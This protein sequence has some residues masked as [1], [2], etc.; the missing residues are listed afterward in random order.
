MKVL[1]NKLQI[2]NA[3][4]TLIAKGAS[5]LAAPF[6]LVLRRF[7]LS[8]RILLGDFIKSWDVL[9]S[10]EYIENHVQKD[11]PIL[12]IGCHSSEIIVALHKLGYSNLTGAD[13]NPALNEM[14][15][16]NSIRYEITN[17]MKTGFEDASFKAITSISVIEHGFDGHALLKEM[18]R[19]L[20]PGGHFIASFDYW[21][22]KIDTTGVKFYGMDWKIFSKAEVIDLIKLASE[23]GLAQVGE[24]NFDGQDRPIRCGGKKYTF[25]WLVLTK[26]N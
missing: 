10:L 23:Y 2:K 17:F 6:W 25:G 11:E 15:F 26:D 12:D 22:E 4:S 1:L 7:G 8:R 24:M 18:S 5:S 16:Q 3:R 13:L 14:P 19:L 21:P 9:E 20:K